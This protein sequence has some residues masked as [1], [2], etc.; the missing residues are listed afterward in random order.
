M[1]SSGRL[2]MISVMPIAMRLAA[3]LGGGPALAG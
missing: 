3:V 1:V 2:T